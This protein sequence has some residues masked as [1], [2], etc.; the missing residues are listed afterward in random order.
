VYIV[1]DRMGSVRGNTQGESFAYY[2][3]GEE[4]TSTVDGRDKFGTYFRDTAGQD[5]AD[6]R[7]YNGGMGR[8][9]SPDPGGIK[10]ANPTDPGSWNRYAYVGGDPVNYIDPG[11]LFRCN[12]AYCQPVS[13]VPPPPSQYNGNNGS[14]GPTFNWGPY[15]GD[16][17]EPDPSDNPY[18]RKVV[19]GLVGIRKNIDPGCLSWLESGIA[20]S[21]VS[22]FN[23]YYNQ[24]LGVGGTPLAGAADFTGTQY[25]GASAAT[26]VPDLPFYITVNTMGAFFQSGLG[27]GYVDDQYAADMNSL[28]SG[29]GS[30]QMFILLHELAHYF[31]A[32]GFDQGDTSIAAQKHNNDM[33]WDKCGKTIKGQIQ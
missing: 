4:R 28:Q 9:W 14:Q 32:Q 24:L 25:Q 6:Q 13:T 30:A 5:Y 21:Q 27:V 3:Y 16:N 2:P 20:G 19:G 11:G 22:V 18:S 12:P 26:N 23:Q 7:Y 17:E 33:I 8:F 29:T 15:S 10:T 1:T 31:K